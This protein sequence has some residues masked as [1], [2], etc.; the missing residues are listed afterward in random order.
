MTPAQVIRQMLDAF[1]S[2]GVAG[3][4]AFYDPEITWI[5]RFPRER[6]LRGPDEVSHG[7]DELEDAGKAVVPITREVVDR[8]PCVVVPGEMQIRERGSV[9]QTQVWWVIRVR[10]GKVLSG[11]DCLSRQQ[12]EAAVARC[13]E[14]P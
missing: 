14:D 13:V 11:E 3:A 6:L 12:L 1:Y 5:S 4:R 9:R 8:G 7:L 10:N 2:S